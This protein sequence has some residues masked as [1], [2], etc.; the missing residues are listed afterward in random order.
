MH[1]LPFDKPMAWRAK[2][3]EGLRVALP[4]YEAGRSDFVP[5]IADLAQEKMRAGMHARLHAA[6]PCISL[7][8][9][10][11][12]F[13][14]RRQKARADSRRLLRLLTRRLEAPACAASFE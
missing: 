7:G 8:A 9:R 4:K 11:P 1:G 13:E 14:E 12:H 2:G 3:G 6:L 5:K 10:H